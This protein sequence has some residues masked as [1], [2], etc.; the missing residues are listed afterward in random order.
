[1]QNQTLFRW[2]ALLLLLGLLLLA[3]IPPQSAF[4]QPASQTNR[5]RSALCG[6]LVFLEDYKTQA[7]LIGLI[8]CNESR[9]LIFA[10]RPAELFDFYRLTNVVIKKG[11]KV[12]TTTYGTLENYITRF[13]SYK[14]IGSCHDCDPNAAAVQPRSAEQASEC[15]A[16]LLDQAA[17]AFPAANPDQQ[18]DE[19]LNNLQAFANGEVVNRACG[20]DSA[21]RTGAVAQQLGVQLGPRLHW[22]DIQAGQ[23]IDWL[24]GLLSDPAVLEACPVMDEIAPKLVA[25]LNQQGFGIDLAAIGE[26]CDLLAANAGGQQTGFTQNSPLEQIPGAR[27]VAAPAG[28]YLLLPASAAARLELACRQSEYVDLT[29]ILRDLTGIREYL[30]TRLAVRDKTRGQIDLASSPLVLSLDARGDGA[31]QERDP[32]R[33]LLHPALVALIPTPMP[34]GAPAPPTT[35]A[36]PTPESS[37]TPTPTQPPPSP[38]PAPTQPPPT[39]TPAPQAAPTGLCP[40]AVGVALLP[41]WSAAI[42]FYQR[43][44]RRKIGA[45]PKND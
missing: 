34:T 39:P 41:G 30:F 11:D 26:G 35:T 31:I 8:P 13:D 2:L 42:K 40:L 21:C 23:A 16:W 19:I 12:T 15:A 38:T 4:A 29:L 9:P 33:S 7:K 32:N 14:Q 10:A 45:S 43:Y 36:P 37:S 3:A 17:T 25:G 20:V 27:S 24:A 5:N 18:F 1:M 22:G 44:L 28:Q 6:R